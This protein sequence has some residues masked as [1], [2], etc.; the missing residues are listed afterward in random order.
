MTWTGTGSSCSAEPTDGRGPDL[1]AVTLAPAPFR[2]AIAGT[3]VP[4][5][6]AL[7]LPSPD[8]DLR[9]SSS[10]ANCQRAITAFIDL[11][12]D[13]LRHLTAGVPLKAGQR[14][15]DFK[16]GISGGTIEIRAQRLS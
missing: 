13:S 16:Q 3:V 1:N 6:F 10:N 5:G 15:V 7:N 11:L 12:R 14:N 4:Q 2:Y 8:L 9:F